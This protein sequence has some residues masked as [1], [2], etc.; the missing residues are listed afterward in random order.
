MSFVAATRRNPGCKASTASAPCS[1]RA[2]SR[3]RRVPPH[4]KRASG[5][6]VKA[7]TPIDVNVI[8][9]TPFG[10]TASPSCNKLVHLKSKRRSDAAVVVMP[11]DTDVVTRTSP[12]NHLCGFPGHSLTRPFRA[13]RFLSPKRTPPTQGLP[14]R[15]ALSR[16][17][18]ALRA[19]G[20]RLFF[21]SRTGGGAK[22]T[23][24]AS[25]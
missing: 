20:D 19:D 25:R 1:P 11:L 24:L 2:P 23:R 8:F 13:P 6:Y 15:Q 18:K 4:R 21:T 14:P 17:N 12:R 7:L 16:A 10:S 22:E 9:S 5:F 3:R